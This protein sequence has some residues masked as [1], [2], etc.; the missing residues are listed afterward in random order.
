M[1]VW[2]S[3]CVSMLGSYS[4][5]L[6]HSTLHWFSHRVGKYD[7][8]Y[9]W[10]KIYLST[11]LQRDGCVHN[12]QYCFIDLDVRQYNTEIEIVI[13]VEYRF[14]I[15][16]YISLS[17]NKMLSQ[18]RLYWF[19][20]DLVLECVGLLL[21]PIYHIKMVYMLLNVYTNNKMNK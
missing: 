17:V 8:V 5:L 1:Q 11:S 7:F 13:Y 12:Y 14:Q 9:N 15:W 18:L 6:K 4:S 2:Y 16:L 20:L 3:L 21:E 19:S 10:L